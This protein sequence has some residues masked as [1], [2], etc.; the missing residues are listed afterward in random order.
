MIGIVFVFSLILSVLATGIV[1]NAA[2]TEKE[3]L[4]VDP[5]VISGVGGSEGL[6]NN[7][8]ADPS[9]PA[10][11]VNKAFT[12]TIAKRLRIITRCALTAR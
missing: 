12:V 4:E 3:Y 1:S 2:N 7:F 8:V 5:A 6:E 10:L 11:G 9:P